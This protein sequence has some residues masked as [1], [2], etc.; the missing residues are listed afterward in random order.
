MLGT[1]ERAKPGHK[2]TARLAALSLSLLLAACGGS[3][4]GPLDEIALLKVHV[5][6]RYG[7]DI[8]GATV[9]APTGSVAT[10]AQGVAVV[11]IG[12]AATSTDLTVSNPSF[13]SQALTAPV[14][15]G[16]SSE[17]QVTLDRV[18]A[19]AGGSLATRS[20]LPSQADAARQTLNFEVELIVVD[21]A[22]RPVEGLGAGDFALQACTPDAASPQ[23]DCVGGSTA[24][25]DNAYASLAAAPE[26]VA[27]V[28]GQPA[29]PYAAALLLDQSGSIA[30]SDP[31]GARL[32]SAKSFLERL[33]DADQAL[34]AAFA[35]DPG[36]LIPT[37]PLAVYGPFRERAAAPSYF[38]TLDA[39]AP[40]TAGSTPLYGSIDGLRAQIA[41]DAALPAALGR[42]IVVF[43]DGKDTTCGDAAS[44][45]T[46]REQVI[47]GANQDAVR[48]FT[49]GLSGGVDLAALGEL[50]NRTG[51]AMLYADNAE[52]LLPL[53]GSVGRLLSLSLPTYRVRWTVSADAPGAFASGAMLLGRVRVATAE[54]PIVVP[55][56][57]GIP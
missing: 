7:A 22:G 1:P 5:V 55:F 12:Q 49:I 23:A 45:R 10:D 24:A 20:G 27:V 21:G 36:A 17:I 41:G 15:P 35:S 44:C 52:Q 32:Y 34:L 18:T 4:S 46:R 51:G 57:V 8:A 25:G 47:A 30:Q 48:L 31:T 3:G 26:A 50:A 28:P 13:H 33:G 2:G 16:G 14:T 6:D 53:Y 37:P 38:A 11:V 19:P 42:A 56:V 43:T 54:G 9:Q 40:L 39:L 29:A